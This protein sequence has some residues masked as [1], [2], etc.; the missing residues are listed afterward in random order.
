MWLTRLAL[1]NAIG[2]LMAS[3]AIVLIGAQSVARL[4]IDLF[5]NLAVPVLIIGTIYPGA[6]PLDAD[7]YLY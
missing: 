5:P 1:R 6:S 2:V 7:P 4:P 3:L